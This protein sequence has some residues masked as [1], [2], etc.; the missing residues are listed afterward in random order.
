M[1]ALHLLPSPARR[2]NVEP[3]ANTLALTTRKRVQPIVLTL[4]LALLLVGRAGAQP[5]DED[6]LAVVAAAFA[7]FAALESFRF[8]GERIVDQKVTANLDSVRNVTTQRI[9]GAARGV[10]ERVS[11]ELSFFAASDD[12]LAPPQEGELTF[13]RIR[14]G[15]RSY[16]RIGSPSA[17]SAAVL[18]E[19]MPVGWFVFDPD[20]IDDLPFGT[21]A[22]IQSFEQMQFIPSLLGYTFDRTTVDAVEELPP[23]KLGEAQMRVINVQMNA[24]SVYLRLER[25]FAAS[26]AAIGLDANEVIEL[27][28]R[29]GLQ[30]EFR[31][32]VGV[33]DGRLHQIDLYTLLVIDPAWGQIGGEPYGTEEAATYRL[34]FSDFNSDVVI[35][36]P[37]VSD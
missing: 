8:E 14:T 2:V 3:K 18:P 30:V 31:A 6:V 20:L 22:V 21:F 1:T 5:P 16:L 17:N 23:E 15:G 29:D 19:Q 13:E 11:V 12:T 26:L 4:L 34:T 28:E 24:P 33:E 25:G 27:F 10:N 7:D 9:D 37:E 35:D 36:A 32:W